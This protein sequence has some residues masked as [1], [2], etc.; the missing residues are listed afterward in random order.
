MMHVLCISDTRQIQAALRRYMDE[1]DDAALQTVLRGSLDKLD[2]YHHALLEPA[3]AGSPAPSGAQGGEIREWFAAFV[4]ANPRAL[5]QLGPEVIDGVLRQAALSNSNAVPGWQFAAKGKVWVGG[6]AALTLCAIILLL[7]YQP[8]QVPLG[9]PGAAT[10]RTRVVGAFAR[11]PASAASALRAVGH[12]RTARGILAAPRIENDAAARNPSRLDVIKQQPVAQKQ[13]TP[14][15]ARALTKRIAATHKIRTA[16][17]IAALPGVAHFTTRLVQVHQV[18]VPSADQRTS[19]IVE[20]APAQ[21]AAD[22]GSAQNRPSSN[23][24]YCYARGTWHPC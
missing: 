1:L 18:S 17:R 6:G 13:A 21:P 3:L 20:Q 15:T 4:A 9:P 2:P 8:P 10:V 22:E 12:K 7:A 23:V 5:E 11:R 16:P 19:Y 14:H 24:S